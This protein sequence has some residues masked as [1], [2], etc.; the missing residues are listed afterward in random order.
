MTPKS[1][2]ASRPARDEGSSSQLCQK[3]RKELDAVS[4]K[5]PL[6]LLA[7]IMLL[8]LQLHLMPL[9]PKPVSPWKLNRT[10]N[11]KEPVS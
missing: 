1:L 3:K 2:M 5:P 9:G 8:Q 6:P 4:L 7:P 10:A 11:L